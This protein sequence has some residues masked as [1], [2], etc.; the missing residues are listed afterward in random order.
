MIR[1]MGA[2]ISYWSIVEVVT[3]MHTFNVI[4]E[5]LKRLLGISSVS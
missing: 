2:Y 4:K 3:Y 5:F 1:T